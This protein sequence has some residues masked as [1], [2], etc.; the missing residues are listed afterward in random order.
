MIKYCIGIA[1]CGMFIA[2]GGHPKV[3]VT[4]TVP[5]GY[6]G[7]FAVL[8]A[9]EVGGLDL[10]KVAAA[11][12][13][14]WSPRGVVVVDMEGSWAGLMHQYEDDIGAV[15]TDCQH[16][17]ATAYGD[18]GDC[19]HVLWFFCGAQ[20][21]GVRFLMGSGFGSRTAKWLIDRGVRVPH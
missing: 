5:R 3:T 20:D 4:H 18:G 21:D 7:P 16:L 6:S 8:R 11:D 1:L 10:P 14:A 2:C 15:R 17:G 12:A 13:W 19:L 9:S